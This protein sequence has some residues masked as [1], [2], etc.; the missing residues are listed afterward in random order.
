MNV[1]GFEI[2][3]GTYLRGANLEGADQSL[4]HSPN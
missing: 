2:K 4:N 1:K 3:P